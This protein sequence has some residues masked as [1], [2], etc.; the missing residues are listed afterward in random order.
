VLVKRVASTTAVAAKV[1]WN[2]HDKSV[3]AK[4][5]GMPRGSDSYILMEL[6]GFCRWLD[7]SACYSRV[8]EYDERL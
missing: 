8:G 6:F 7:D 2:L 4:A 3:D 1:D 5:F